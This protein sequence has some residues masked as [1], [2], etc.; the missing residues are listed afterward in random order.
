MSNE[1]E[2]NIQN[3][4][5]V[6]GMTGGVDSIAAAFLLQ[7]Q[8]FQCIAIGMIFIDEEEIKR[9][10]I[11]A[12]PKEEEFSFVTSTKKE[13]TVDDKIKFLQ[14]GCSIKDLEKVNAI[15]ERMN[16]PFY[17]VNAREE[18]KEYI[19]DPFVASRL[20]GDIFIPCVACNNLKMN[21]LCEKAKVLNA[22]YIAT[23]HYAKVYKQEGLNCYHIYSSNDDEYD[24]SYF[25]SNLEQHHLDK[26]ILPLADLR[27]KDVIKIVENFGLPD[28]N[29]RDSKTIC[30]S[31][32]NSSF[33][34]EAYSPVNFRSE[35]VIINKETGMQY[36][37]HQG[38]HNYFVGQ[39]NIP[40]KAGIG[41]KDVERDKVVVEIVPPNRVFVGDKESLMFDICAV[42]NVILAPFFDTSN[43]VTVFIK[44]AI[45]KDRI[46]AML[47]FKS[48]NVC[49]IKFEEEV[50]GLTKGLHLTFY[51]KEKRGA[52]IIGSGKIFF[53]QKSIIEEK[54]GQEEADN[55]DE[56]K[57]KEIIAL[58]DEFYL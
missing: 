36:G 6:I 12:T 54:D 15:C 31:G 8:G 34:I 26:L 44:Y 18:Y 58:D 30:F 53:L 24:Q 57:K 38:I 45:D 23:G 56:S 33:F 10:I 43:P 42:N 37:E 29:R 51:D 3:K 46:K 25:L 14:E 21:I 19:L 48:L 17:A 2:I 7:K 39:T 13:L 9:R 35:G 27:K 1:S 20:S 22:S 41:H 5:V 11:E 32:S 28:E 55:L 52:K 16:I 47:Y 4:K 50:F 49:F 40:V